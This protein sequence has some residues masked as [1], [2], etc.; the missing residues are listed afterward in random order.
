MQ[1]LN[2]SDPKLNQ[3]DRI[4]FYVLE[5]KNFVG[6]ATITGDAKKAEPSTYFYKVDTGK[7]DFFPVDIDAFVTQTDNG[8]LID[9]IELESQPN[10]RR[11]RLPPES[12]L[13]I[14]EDDFEMVSELVTEVLE[15]IEEEIDDDDDDYSEEDE[16]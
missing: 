4:L 10:F 15:E 9:T 1:S 12:L 6:V 14:N 7:V 11:M 16:L 5:T 8:A 3:G 13:E 2:E